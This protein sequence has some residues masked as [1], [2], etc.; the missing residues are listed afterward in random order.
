MAP[1]TSTTATLFETL[2]ATSLLLRQL[3][4]SAAATVDQIAKSRELVTQTRRVVADISADVVFSVEQ[5]PP[6]LHAG[7]EIPNLAGPNSLSA[8]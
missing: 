1:T 2:A 4:S 3:R 6:I 7:A 8:V 5:Q